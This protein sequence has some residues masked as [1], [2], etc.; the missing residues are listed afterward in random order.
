MKKAL[1]SCLLL[2]IVGVTLFSGLAAAGI[3]YTGTGWWTW[4][5]TG[6]FGGGDV[7]SNLSDVAFEHSTSVMNADGYWGYSGTKNAGVKAKASKYAVP[8]ETDYAYYK[9]ITPF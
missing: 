6:L 5:T 9:I 1:A 7:Y 3:K 4:G 8:W 2:T